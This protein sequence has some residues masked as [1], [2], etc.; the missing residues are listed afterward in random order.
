MRKSKATAV[1]VGTALAVS[2]IGAPVATVAQDDTD[3]TKIV[4]LYLND[5]SSENADGVKRIDSVVEE[6]ERQ[7]PDIDVE[8]EGYGF[9]ELFQQIQ[10]RS[11][12]GDTTPDVIT[13]DSPRNSSY[14][15]RG[16]LEP[17]DGLFTEEEIDDWQDQP[18]ASATYEGKLISAPWVNATQLLFYN[19]PLLDAAGVAY[20]G[21]D[22]RWTWE[23]VVEAAQKVKEANPDVSGFDWEQRTAIYQLQ[24]LAGSLGG[25][26]L[27][28]DGLSAEGIINSPEWVEAM[29][30]YQ[31]V[32][33]DWGLAPQSDAVNT[34]DAFEAGDVAMMLAGPWNIGR[35]AGT[36]DPEVWGVSRHPYFEAGE[37]S[38]P[39]GAWNL[40]LNPNSEHKEAAQRF[41]KFMTTAEGI[42]L[43]WKAPGDA[44]ASEAVVAQIE[45]DPAFETWPQSAFKVMA[46]ESTVNPVLR[47]VTAAYLEYEDIMNRT[48]ADIRNGAD[49]KQSLDLAAQALEREFAK[50]QQ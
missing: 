8:L 28:E 42:D 38:N 3:Q 32:Y 48:F 6:F 14:G 31:N 18:L 40:G 27:G 33:N 26:P 5:W 1:L 39:T 15:L 46:R 30:F 44:P 12:S 19:K 7:N 50:Y 10:I 9:G 23:Q 36:M 34:S 43:W 13:V 20:P 45:T 49:V 2:A 29:T 21:E 16:W 17:L 4:Y 24:P 35:Y 22:E 11:Q 25:A 47:P 37:P 41:I